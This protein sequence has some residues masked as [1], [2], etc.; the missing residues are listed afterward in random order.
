MQSKQTTPPND[1][2]RDAGR[3]PP[4]DAEVEHPLGTG[5]GAAVGGAAAGAAIG[6]AAGALGA[7]A[8]AAAGAVAGAWAGRKIA[9]ALSDREED[10]YWQAHYMSRPYVL[11]GTSYDDYGPAYRYGAHA[12]RRYP[13]RSFDEVEPDLARGWDE[14]RGASGLEWADALPAARDAWEHPTHH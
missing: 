11:R 2:P 14:A 12:R 6:A 7:A 10:E 1:P 5:V 4:I 3:D 13:A 9:A 8:G